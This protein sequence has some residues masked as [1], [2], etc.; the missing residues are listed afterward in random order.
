MIFYQV[1]PPFKPIELM[2]LMGKS[3]IKWGIKRDIPICIAINTTFFF[4]GGVSIFDHQAGC[5][6]ESCLLPMNVV[7]SIIN[8]PHLSLIH[9][10]YHIYIY[11]LVI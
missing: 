7:N 1:L 3:S 10:S 8:Y 4:L 11:H 9:G 5:H 6:F 2:V